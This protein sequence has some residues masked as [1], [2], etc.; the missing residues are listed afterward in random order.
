MEIYAEI[1]AHFLSKQKAQI[2]FPNLQFNAAEIV[3]QQSYLTLCQIKSIIADGT[4]DDAE[5]FQR[6]EEIVCALEEIGVDG[7]GR[8]DFG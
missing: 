5:C 2:L 8:H 7:G 3:A 4:I 1:L 6:I